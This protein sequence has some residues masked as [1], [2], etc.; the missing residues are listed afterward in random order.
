M[1][2]FCFS[3]TKDV[4]IFYGINTELFQCGSEMKTKW[5]TSIPW[6]FSAKINVREKRFELDFPPCKKE[7]ELV[8]IRYVL[9]VWGKR[10]HSHENPDI[11]LK[12]FYNKSILV[13]QS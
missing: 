13:R 4:W 11:V 7:I 9:G 2:L 5:P 12:K 10:N 1:N 3:Y 8:S 6:K